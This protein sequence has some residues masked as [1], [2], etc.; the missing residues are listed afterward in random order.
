[1]SGKEARARIKINKLLENA[2]WRFEQDSSGPANLVLESSGSLTKAYM[3]DTFG[4]DFEKSGKSY[5]DYLLIGSD[6]RPLV[7]FRSK[8]R[9]YTPSQCQR[10]SQ[11]ICSCPKYSIY[12]V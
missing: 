1:M 12:R 7:L 2:G 6:H 10:T 4:E 8:K 3:N 5:N 9:K 11:K